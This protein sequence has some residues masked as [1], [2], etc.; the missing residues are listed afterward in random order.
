M[1][2]CAKCSAKLIEEVIAGL[3]VHLAQINI[4]RMRAALN[5][6]IMKGFADQLVDVNRSAE[7][8]PGFIWRLKT[9]EGDAT[10]IRAYEDELILV[11]MSVWESIES[12]REFT[13]RSHHA[14]VFRDRQQWFE[15][16]NET[17]LALWWIPTG[18][19]P[20][21]EEGKSRLA[22]IEKLGPTPEAFTFKKIF[23]P[24][25]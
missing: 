25:K 3:P 4:A 10:N 14:A 20:T 24:T 9:E 13:Y 17:Q 8:S 23:D 1:S 19:T 22:L 16:M 12:L 5:D 7:S 18:H 6:P 15:R 11:N 2:A 21:V